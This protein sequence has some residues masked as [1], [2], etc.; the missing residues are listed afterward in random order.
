MR[1]GAASVPVITSTEVQAYETCHRL[2]ADAQCT[3][4]EEDAVSGCCLSSNRDEGI[5]DGQ[6]GFQVD[7]TTHIEDDGAWS[8]QTC[9]AIA[10]G[11]WLW[12]VGV[13]VERGHMIDDA[14]ASSCGKT[15]ITL[16]AWEGEVTGAERP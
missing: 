8:R 13:V 11:A 16:G 1:V 15:A 3:A 9:H 6:T 10:E 4:F 2:I 14:V 5:G 12:V 7:D